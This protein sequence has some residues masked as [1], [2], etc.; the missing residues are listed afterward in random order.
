MNKDNVSGRSGAA[1]SVGALVL[2]CMVGAMS[3]AGGLGVAACGAD[4]PRDEGAVV[5]DTGGE[6]RGQ[7]ICAGPADRKCSEGEYCSATRAGRCP[8]ARVFGVCAERPEF[9][10]KIFKPVCGC[11][12]KTY[13]NSCVAASAG[14]AVESDGACAPEPTGPACGGLLGIPCEGKA[15]CIDDPSD[16]CDPKNGGNDCI[17]ICVDAPPPPPPKGPAC[18]G[19]LGTPCEGTAVCIDDPS[20]D[21]DPNKGGADCIGIC[22]DAPPPKGPACG[23][24]LGIPCEGKA[25]CVDDPS[26]D[27][28][29]KNGGN[30]CIGIC[31]DATP[32]PPPPKGPACGGFPGT[33][34]KGK[35]ICVDDPSD[36]CD[37][38]NGG[39][40]C[41]GIC[42]CEAMTQKVCAPGSHFD[43]SPDV[44]D[45]APDTNPCA[46][47]TCQVGSTCIVVD[48]KGVC[49]APG[50]K[51]G[52]NT[53]SAGQFCCNPSCGICAPRGGACTQVICDATL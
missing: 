10:P 53:C 19:L 39:A 28:D 45:C 12:G 46:A 9:C 52:A 20:D 6:L 47:V 26:D 1:L 51:C 48:G 24:L 22:V 15:V 37:P 36:D 8:S 7:R 17:G 38:K 42:R 40:D 11:D 21:C 49:V 3:I 14:V 4:G 41:I 44:C 30:D 23:G 5:T 32:P 16:D 27:C 13:S 25:V 29:P 2:R 50:P 18:G 35:A 34:C 33:P 31:V 43:P